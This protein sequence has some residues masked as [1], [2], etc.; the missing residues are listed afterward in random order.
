MRLTQLLQH[1]GQLE[2]EHSIMRGSLFGEGETGANNKLEP[3]S[4]DG[5]C[6]DAC[7]RIASLVGDAATINGRLNR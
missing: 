1:I 6:A 7:Q 5:M 2:H 3:T 4:I